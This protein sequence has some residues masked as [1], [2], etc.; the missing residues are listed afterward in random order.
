MFRVMFVE[1]RIPPNTG[2]AIRMTAIT[3]C[4]LHLIEPL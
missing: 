3:G 4:E 1:P 2:N